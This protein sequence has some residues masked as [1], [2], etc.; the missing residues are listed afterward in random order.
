[1]VQGSLLWLFVVLLTLGMTLTLALNLVTPSQL[2]VQIGQPAVSDIFAP[3]SLTYTSNLL[4]AQARALERDSVAEVYS[5]LD[6]S[7]GRAQKGRA[8]AVFSFIETVRADSQATRESKLAYLRA[9][10]GLTV[11]DQVGAGLLDLNQVDYEEAKSNVLGIIEELMRQQIR[12]SQLREFQRSARQEAGLELTPT[13]ESV[14]TTIAPQFIV[15]TVFYDEAATARLRLEAEA[16]VDP[17]VRTITKDQ[18]VVRVGDLVTD[19]DI[20]LLTELGLLQREPD[21]RDFSSLFIAS[22][23]SVVLLALYWQQ[24]HSHLR[25]GARYLLALAIIML[26]FTLLARLMTSGSGSLAYWY[27]MA[28]LSMLLAVTFDVRLS[29]LA[30]VI[31]SALLGFVGR[32]SLELTTYAASG[33]LLAVLT[34]SSA[35]AQRINAFFRAG[36]VAAVGHVVAVLIFRLP[37]HVEVVEVVQYTLYGLANGVLS[38]ALTLVG[39][40]VLGS[41][42]GITTT[43][44]LQELSRLDHPLLQE[45]LR[46]A[47]GTYHHSIMVANLAEQAAERIRANGT[48]VRVGAFYHDIGKMNRPPFFTENQEGF[49]PHDSLDPYSSARI[50][51]SHVSD[52][53]ELARR[54]RLPDRIRDFIAEHHGD[55]LVKSILAKALEQAGEEADQVDASQFRHRGPR[56]RSRETGIVLLADT[57]DATS[58]AIRPD[59]EKAIVRLVNGI[60]EDDLAD[61]QLDDSGLTLGD[62][63]LIR[64]SF[65]ETLK[66]RYHVRVKYP[67][68]EALMQGDEAVTVPP[69]IISHRSETASGP[70]LSQDLP[71]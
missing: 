36:L 4:T 26:L 45:L 46:R 31:M 35:R 7:I 57:V 13:Q 69:P 39:F 6:L 68:N 71:G 25:E 47:P 59:S 53:L 10:D 14:V 19:V 54:Y 29:M 11:E 27:P 66:G 9:I 44:Q 38:A 42:F 65:I 2:S 17:I 48:L 21:F 15:P 64:A 67:G 61:G 32:S 40:F 33:G 20:E 70:Q 37:L 60:V 22:L 18:R 62:I 8:R 23:V 52:G 41:L 55:K 1:M 58:S 3:R 28:A 43:L 63:K 56:P 30:T 5:P 49:N 16:S 50:I 51:I 12:E 24:F 34:L